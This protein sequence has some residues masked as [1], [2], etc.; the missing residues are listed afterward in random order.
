MRFDEQHFVIVGDEEKKKD[1]RESSLGP[2]KFQNVPS[3]LKQ[4]LETFLRS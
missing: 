3:R 4:P 2:E 1:S